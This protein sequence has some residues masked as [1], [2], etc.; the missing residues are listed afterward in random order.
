[1]KPAASVTRTMR[2]ESVRLVT[3][4]TRVGAKRKKKQKQ[5]RKKINKIINASAT[6]TVHMYS[7]YSNYA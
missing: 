2:P 1:M 5:E 6:V 7:N 3:R 4:T